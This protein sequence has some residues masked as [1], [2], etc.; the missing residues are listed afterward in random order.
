MQKLSSYLYPNRIELLADLAGFSVEYTNVYQRNVKIYNG[1]DNTIEF[2]IKNAD[3]KRVDLATLSHIELNIMDAAGY[4]LPNSPYTVTPTSI[5]GI[6]TVTIP[7]DDLVDLT[8]QYL[9]YSVSAI[10]NGK[11]VMLYSNSKFDA[12]GTIEL[13]GNAMPVVRDPRIIKAFTSEIDLNGNPIF[14]S[15]AIITKFYEAIPTTS[16]DFEIHVTGFSGTIWID[17]ATTDTISVESFRP[18]GKPF[19]SWTQLPA[20]GLF[21]GVIPYGN[22]IPIGDYTYFRVSYQAS[23]LTGYGATFDVIKSGG[24]YTVKVKA[25]GTNYM[26]GS[27]IKIPGSQLGGLDGVN[28]IIVTVVSVEG[29]GS[30]YSMGSIGNISWT[31]TASSGTGTYVVTGSNYSGVVDSVTII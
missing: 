27:L 16:F 2:D 6:A 26:A 10:K 28:D 15:S 23:S 24:N 11:D 20:D 13:V 12:I 4:G 7:Q 30:S 9:T 31:G 25:Y 14:H 21:T 5:K 8:P 22:S 18:A 17:A 29:I 3:Q 1:I 19:G